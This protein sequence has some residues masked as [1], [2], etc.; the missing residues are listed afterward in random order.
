[1]A[2][3]S[4][5]ES[6]RNLNRAFAALVLVGSLSLSGC[7]TFCQGTICGDG[8]VVDPDGGGEIVERD[9]GQIAVKGGK[10]ILEAD[11]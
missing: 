6:S 7:C 9:D 3:R 5:L 2:S 8:T 10:C 11:A 1:M 4:I